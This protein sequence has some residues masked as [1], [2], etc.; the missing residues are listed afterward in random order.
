MLFE[1]GCEQAFL[2]KVAMEMKPVVFAPSESPPPQHF[3]VVK[4]G[5][6]AFGP[7]LVTAGKM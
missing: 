4:K 5:V 7:K 1:G 3:Y 2:V 6:V